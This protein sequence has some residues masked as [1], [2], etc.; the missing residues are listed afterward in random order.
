MEEYNVKLEEYNK[1]V[2]ENQAAID[3]QLNS[4]PYT[5][6]RPSELFIK[7]PFSM[8]PN[9]NNLINISQENAVERGTGNNCYDMGSTYNSETIHKYQVN[10]GSVIRAEYGNV[11]TDTESGRAL[12]VR[13][14][15][16]NFHVVQNNVDLPQ[17][18]VP[19]VAVQLSNF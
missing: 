17:F 14:T 4:D 1:A 10:P 6:L 13:L 15:Y 12:N 18:G 2:G 8:N 9:P 16:D 7:N 19:A 11:A 5:T 3:A